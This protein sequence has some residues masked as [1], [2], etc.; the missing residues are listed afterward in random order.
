MILGFSLKIF[1][2]LTSVTSKTC[3]GQTMGFSD[4]TEVSN[5]SW[6]CQLLYEVLFVEF[7]WKLKH[8]E[9]AISH[10]ALLD[11]PRILNWPKSPHRLGN[12][13]NENKRFCCTFRYLEPKSIFQAY[14]NFVCSE[15]WV[16]FRENQN[17]YS[18]TYIHTYIQSFLCAVVTT[19]N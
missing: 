6:R 10:W 12:C 8:P 11:P 7:G 1:F 19:R 2:I 13:N 9:T 16:T 3:W 15:Y 5:F 18:N 4:H 17:E 14:L